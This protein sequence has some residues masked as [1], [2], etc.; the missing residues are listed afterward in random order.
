LAVGNQHHGAVPDIYGLVLR[1]ASGSSR[2]FNSLIFGIQLLIPN[3]KLLKAI[4]TKY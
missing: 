4:N 2:R 1:F 3:I